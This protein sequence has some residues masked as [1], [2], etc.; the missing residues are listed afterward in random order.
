MDLYWYLYGDDASSYDG[1]LWPLGPA[2][3]TP[4][5]QPGRP[6]GSTDGLS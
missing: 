1:T 6:F 2:A 4:F 3:D 5:A